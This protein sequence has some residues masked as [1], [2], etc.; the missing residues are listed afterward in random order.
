MMMT[1]ENDTKKNWIDA[2]TE[3]AQKLSPRDTVCFYTDYQSDGIWIPIV[4][5]LFANDITVCLCGKNNPD[6]FNTIVESKLT[7]VDFPKEERVLNCYP[8]G[9]LR[10]RAIID[11]SNNCYNTELRP[12]YKVD[13]EEREEVYKDIMEVLRN[14]GID[15]RVRMEDNVVAEGV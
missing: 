4:N 5:A 9:S 2:L 12:V 14:C 3:I 11:V 7:I 13:G 8:F 6:I 1:L 10:A 15:Y